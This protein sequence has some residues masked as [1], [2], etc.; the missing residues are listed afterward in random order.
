M[1]DVLV[2]SNYKKKLKRIKIVDD[3][4]MNKQFNNVKMKIELVYNRL[5][6]LIIII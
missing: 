3:C 1:V 6:K 2:E 4:S 5:I